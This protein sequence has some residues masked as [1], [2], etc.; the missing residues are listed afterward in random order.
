[1]RRESLYNATAVACCGV[2]LASC[3]SHYVP[4]PEIAQATKALPKTIDYNWDVRPILS[5]NCFRCHGLATSTRKAGLRLDIADS[6]YGRL[7]EDPDKRAIV[8]GRPEESELIRR[9]TSSDPDER[10]P[11]KESH[12]VLA[13]V[14]IAILLRWV[15]QGARYKQHWAYIPPALVEP[16]PSKS[17]SRAVNAIDRYVFARLDTEQ[18]AP[19]PEADKETL[20]NRVTL[21]LTGLPP[22]LEEVDAFVAD[23]RPD[24][25]EQLVDRLLTTPAYAERMAQMWLDVAR[26]GDSDGYLND[27]TG[28]LLHPY[29]DWVI[30]AFAQN[31]PYDRFVTWQVA[32]DLLP[33]PTTEQLLATSF[34]RMGKR[35]NEGG[36]IDEEFRVE[37]VNERAEL[38]GKAFMGLTVACAR[39]HDHKYDVI[40]QAEY[41]QL[42][43][44]FN[45]IDE[46]GIHTESV[47]GAPMGPTLAWPTPKQAATLAQAHR[48][49]VAKQTE[50][51][52]TLAAV[53]KE[54]ETKAQ[55][56]MQAPT[57]ELAALVAASI[58][59]GLD[60][61]YPLDSAYVASFESLMIGPAEGGGFG[62]RRG[63]GGPGDDDEG[64]KQML[65]HLASEDLSRAFVDAVK[66]GFKFH[67]PIAITRRQLPIGL[68]AEELHWTP[69]GIPGAPPGAVNNAA[70]IDGVK[71]KAVLLNDSVGFAA[72]DV[73]RYER[74]Q[75]FSL[76]L[77]I[78][79]RE[80]APYDFV[81]VL[82]N[83]GFSGSGGYELALEENR[84][85]FDLVHQAPYNMLSVQTAKPL[86]GG[87]WIHVS[88]TY[89]GSSRASGM[90]LYL[91]GAPA[92]TEIYRD[93]LTRSTLPR[94]GHSL[95]SSYYGLAFGKRFQVNEFKG[96]A[97]DE[98]RVFH[99]ALNP[100]EVQY[101]QDPALL[102][103]AKSDTTRGQLVALLADEDERVIAGKAGVRAAVE[104]EMSV[105]TAIPQLMITR[106][107]PTPRPTYILER[108]L[109]TQHG[110]EVQPG[111]PTRVF[112]ST[113][114][115]PPNR[116]GLIEWLFDK[117]NP[118]TARVF[119]NRLWQTHFG[120]G[121]VETVEDFGT[122]GANPT[123]PELLDWLALEF[124]KSGWDMRHMQKLM[125]LS[126]TYRQSSNVSKAMAQR[127][128]KNLLLARGPRYRLPAEAI[129]DNALFASGLLVTKVGGD[130][131]F[132]YQPPRVW[133]GSSPGL[134]LYPQTVPDDEYHRRTMYTY[135]KRNAPPPSLMVFD[136]ADRNVSTVARKISSTPLQALVLLNDTQYTEAYRKMAER[137]IQAT[138]DPNAQIVMLFRL[139]TRRRP[140]AAELA[141]LTKY[142]A[143]QIEHMSGAPEDVRKLMSIGVA[144]ASVGLDQTQ[145]AALTM[146][147]AAVM[148]SPDA[149]TLR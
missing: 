37:Y 40:S 84:L 43:G 51:A 128:P 81:E 133:E 59:A 129:R 88:A 4:P 109:Y 77:W 66:T 136:M 46:R 67:N 54:T 6:A 79:L 2:L 130:S 49:T 116:M 97:L 103:R 75:E 148:N 113:Q 91:N 102:D 127:D 108:G 29:R 96:G 92:N 71:G 25:Y 15:E 143:E 149:C 13:P 58:D 105:E 139:A 72:R 122:Q 137:V 10:M 12:K 22:S 147:A 104:A 111:V 118:L 95:Y 100:L 38:M 124:V 107:A 70:F 76:D 17:G 131:V 32:G 28:R 94:G 74:T 52:A 26:Y 140:L 93:R 61:Y 115:L 8:P 20:I 82:Y 141:I 31:V 126:A 65:G 45:S 42:T 19:A 44:Y 63:G 3:G 30:S 132:P 24:A 23:T 55:A 135:F 27:S 47:T 11:P 14:E 39:C 41:Y 121:I 69:S 78:R 144:P 110:K 34:L 106:D 21:D 9:I 1:M 117:K 80:G 36:I 62:R 83:Q 89:D 73:G 98:I 64:R 16:A 112:A 145:V 123:H 114:T 134:N 18:L 33:N 86:P 85:K 68:K 50:Y 125:V 101:L 53:R 7:P 56:V 120:T 99:K 5:Q 48:E 146:V 35:N 90:K 57:H 119:V 87:Q 60:A 142:R 138:P